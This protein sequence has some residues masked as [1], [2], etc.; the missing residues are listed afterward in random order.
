MTDHVGLSSWP[1]CKG[2]SGSHC[3]F[4]VP[5]SSRFATSKSAKHVASVTSII[6]VQIQQF[7]SSRELFRVNCAARRTCIVGMFFFDSLLSSRAVVCR[8]FLWNARVAVLE[9]DDPCWHWWLSIG[10]LRRERENKAV[11]DGRCAQFV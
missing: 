2:P 5:A 8:G 10:T 1:L 9:S 3:F 11:R 7:V 4:L 6:C